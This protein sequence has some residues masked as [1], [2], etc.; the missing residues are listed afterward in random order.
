MTDPTNPVD[1]RRTADE[2]RERA[3]S[4]DPDDP[5][6]FS[7]AVVLEDALRYP[8][9]S[10]R[11]E[12]RWGLEALLA[13][14]ASNAGWAVAALR[15]RVWLLGR[16]D[17]LSEMDRA[18]RDRGGHWAQAWALATTFDATTTGYW[19]RAVDRT[20]VVAEWASGMWAASKGPF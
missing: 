4:I 19:Q 18:E 20:P 12:V 16:D 11:T 5:H 17:V 14:A 15:E 8:D 7:R 1:V 13:S 3:R 9:S 2:I 6:W 10:Q